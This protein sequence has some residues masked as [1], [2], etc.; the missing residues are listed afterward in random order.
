MRWTLLVLTGCLHWARPPVSGGFESVAAVI[1]V[2]GNTY[3]VGDGFASASGEWTHAGVGPDTWVAPTDDADSSRP[4]GSEWRIG[5]ARCRVV[6]YAAGAEEYVDA[7][8]N[9]EG[10]RISDPTAPSCGGP[11]IWARLSCDQPVDADLAVPWGRTVPGTVDFDVD[12]DV[13]W[14]MRAAEVLGSLPVWSKAKEDAAARA[15]ADATT[16][17]DSV[18]VKA[19]TLG[20]RR[21]AVVDARTWS[22]EGANYCGGEDF[23]TRAILLLPDG[24]GA[25]VIDVMRDDEAAVA[26]VTDVDGDGVPEL[27]FDFWGDTTIVNAAGES[28]VLRHQS[29]CVCGC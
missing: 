27:V 25:A 22:G 6:G 28:R 15:V 2:V 26:D 16:V 13:A 21:W 20:R 8:V 5:A 12:N 9:D 19:Y 18:D 11:A 4:V 29:I 23:F 1:E 10:E 7:Y 14:S 17:G 24:G 3:L